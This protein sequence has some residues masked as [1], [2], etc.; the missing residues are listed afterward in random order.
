[1][2]KRFLAS[3]LVLCMVLTLLPI[4]TLAA[5]P[6][7]GSFGENVTWTLDDSRHIACQRNRRHEQLLGKYCAME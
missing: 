2:K 3:V 4:L 6:L 5:A 1:M 7:S